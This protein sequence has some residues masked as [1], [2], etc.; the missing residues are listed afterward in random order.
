MNKEQKASSIL[1]ANG[2]MISASKSGYRQNNP[3]N[4]SIF[5]ANLCT[6]NEKIWWGDMDVT[7]E[8]HIIGDLAYILGEDLYILYEMDGRFENE[9]KPIINRYAV[10]FFYDGGCELSNSLS[11]SYDQHLRLKKEQNA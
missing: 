5:N 8:Q 6:K 1:G 2:K 10:K 4:L 3:E 7:R 11:Q 9:D